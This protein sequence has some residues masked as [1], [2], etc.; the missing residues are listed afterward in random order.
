M[1]DD[2]LVKQQDDRADEAL[3]RD[4]EYGAPPTIIHVRNQDDPG[5]QHVDPPTSAEERHQ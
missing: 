3:L 5:V 2:P 4:P 1:E